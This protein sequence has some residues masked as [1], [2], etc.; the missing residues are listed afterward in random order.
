ML[1]EIAVASAFERTDA[2]VRQAEDV[3]PEFEISGRYAS[4]TAA[5]TRLAAR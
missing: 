4:N 3:V 5:L 2:A 1:E